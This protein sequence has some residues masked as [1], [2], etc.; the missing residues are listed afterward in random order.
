VQRDVTADSGKPR[1]FILCSVASWEVFPPN[2]AD[3]SL[4]CGLRFFWASFIKVHAVFSAVFA[5][6]FSY[7]RF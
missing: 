1:N 4:H 6:I 3:F 7:Q 2:W 5:K